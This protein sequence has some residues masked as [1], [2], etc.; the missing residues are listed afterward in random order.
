VLKGV[1]GE[2][3]MSI[4]PV[5]FLVIAIIGAIFGF[6]DIIPNNSGIARAVF[7]VFTVL[8]LGAL[9]VRHYSRSS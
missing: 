5:I 3:D 7:Y 8:F 4:W 6:G 9:A 2:N 1:F